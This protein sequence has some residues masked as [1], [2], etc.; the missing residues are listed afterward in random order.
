[1]ADTNYISHLT[2]RIHEIVVDCY[3]I[4]LKDT[5]CKSLTLLSLQL[6]RSASGITWLLTGCCLFGT[7]H[8]SSSDLEK[9]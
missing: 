3:L 1:M 8:S 2:G 5:Y 6:L 9:G 4:G 7:F